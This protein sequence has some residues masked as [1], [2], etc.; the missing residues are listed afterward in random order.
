MFVVIDTYC[1]YFYV[2]L[3][4]NSNNTSTSG[5]QSWDNTGGNVY[6]PGRLWMGCLVVISILTCCSRLLAAW[7]IY[8]KPK[9]YCLSVPT[10]L[11]L[12]NENLKRCFVP[13]NVASLTLSKKVEDR[14]S[15]PAV[16]IYTFRFCIFRHAGP[17][18]MTLS[19][20][21]DSNCTFQ[22]TY[23]CW[24]NICLNHSNNTITSTKTFVV[25]TFPLIQYRLWFTVN[26]GNLSPFC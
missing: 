7:R 10:I 2:Y 24:S 1:W 4:T 19:K 21:V 15:V 16:C 25:F 22:S 26:F 18:T 23:S 8:F 13:S 20:P 14:Y 9:G 3:L 17:L 11:N 12:R 6:Q 5:Y